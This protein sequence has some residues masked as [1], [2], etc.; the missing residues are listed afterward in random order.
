MVHSVLPV[1]V[2]AHTLSKSL[3]R[4]HA[5]ECVHVN[6]LCGNPAGVKIVQQWLQNSE[7]VPE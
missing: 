4:L 3:M 7:A 5:F 1:G 6:R 2:V